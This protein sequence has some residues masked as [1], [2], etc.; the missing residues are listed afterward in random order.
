MDIYNPP[1]YRH[2]TSD[3]I[4]YRTC[5]LEE[6]GRINSRLINREMGDEKIYLENLT[7]VFPEAHYRTEFDIYINERN[8]AYQY[9]NFIDFNKREPGAFSRDND[10]LLYE[11]MAKFY[12]DTTQARSFN[13]PFQSQGFVYN[14][15]KTGIWSHH[16]VPFYICCKSFFR[17]KLID[18]KANG[19]LD[20]YWLEEK[21]QRKWLS[22]QAPNSINDYIKY[23]LFDMQGRLIQAGEWKVKEE[24]NRYS[25]QKPSNS[26]LYLL[27]L[28][29][30]QL[31]KTLKMINP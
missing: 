28:K 26:G 20:A 16:D 9:P 31:S 7:Q 25:I 27:N 1:L 12:S 18:E 19:I 15:P 6:E 24:S 17:K 22:V 10:F 3:P 4:Y 30:G 11:N 21:D 13:P 8:P 2:F 29:I 14:P 5:E 23:S